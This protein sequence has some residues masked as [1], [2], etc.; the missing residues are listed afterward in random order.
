MSS[1]PG[2]AHPFILWQAPPPLPPQIR[3]AAMLY[4]AEQARDADDLRVLLAA[5]GLDSGPCPPAAGPPSMPGGARP[6][7]EP[8]VRLRP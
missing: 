2:G 3:R 8:R 1:K 6:V 5:L 7:T 4:I